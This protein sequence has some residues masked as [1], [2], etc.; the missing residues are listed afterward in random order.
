MV[1]SKILWCGAADHLDVL[2][3]F[4]DDSVHAGHVDW[5]TSG[6]AFGRKQFAEMMD[7]IVEFQLDEEAEG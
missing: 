2:G 7:R 4:A 3:H 6:T 1:W 5:L